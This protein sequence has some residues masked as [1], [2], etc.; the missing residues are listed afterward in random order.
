MRIQLI[1]FVLIVIYRIK[2]VSES[3]QKENKT[4][5]TFYS[6]PIVALDIIL[7]NRGR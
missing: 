6:I 5:V 1:F 7:Q 2:Y 4:M 3:I